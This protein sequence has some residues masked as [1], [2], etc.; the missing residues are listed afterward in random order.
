M[1][2]VLLVLVIAAVVVLAIIEAFALVDLSLVRASDRECVF[3]GYMGAVVWD[4]Q[5]YCIRYNSDLVAEIAPL[6]E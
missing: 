5:A 2:D 4:K 3:Q 1:E 6:D